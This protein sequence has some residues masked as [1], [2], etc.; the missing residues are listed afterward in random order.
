MNGSN[1][2]TKERNREVGKC[3]VVLS[4]ASVLP[5]ERRCGSKLLGEA[6]HEDLLWC[7]RRGGQTGNLARKCTDCDD[8]CCGRLVDTRCFAIL[9]LFVRLIWAWVKH[10]MLGEYL[11]EG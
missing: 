9:S 10:S 11:S 6:G 1:L 8:L 5:L 3:L 7:R 4:R 2:G